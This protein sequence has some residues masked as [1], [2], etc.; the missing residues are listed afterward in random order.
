MKRTSKYTILLYLIGVMFSFYSCVEQFTPKLDESNTPN[1]LVVD[2]QITDETGPFKV[3][4]TNSVSVY[5]DPN[6]LNKEHPVYGADVQIFDDK[7]NTFTLYET[8]NGWYETE[9]KKLKAVIG[10]TYSLSITGANGNQYESSPVTMVEV[11]DINSVHFKEVQRTHFDE[12]ELVQENWLD[13]LVDCKAPISEGVYLRWEFEETWKFEMPSR[14]L[15]DHGMFGPPA[16]IEIIDI[17][18]EKKICWVT[19]PSRQILIESTVGYQKNQVRNFVLQT[20]GPNSDRLNI[21]YSILVKQYSINRELYGFFKK[22]R[23]S[24]KESGGMYA[25][26]PRQ[27]FGNITCCNTEKKVLGYFFASSVKTKRIFI[28]QFEHDISKGSA[29]DGCG[30]TT[31]P[32]QYQNIYFYGIGSGRVYSTNKYCTDCRVRG[33]N[34]KPYFWED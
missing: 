4:L 15:V 17:D 13:I 9:N 6:V 21:K 1:L 14:V 16:S 7:G 5:S 18:L 28:D 34:V 31:S 29:Y 3:R 25:K 12:L 20:I 19:E 10:N 22:L 8:E 30:W 11:P 27:V 2:G 24:N 32:P 23:E 26:T 33:T